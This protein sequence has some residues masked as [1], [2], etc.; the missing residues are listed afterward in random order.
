MKVS[1]TTP[2]PVLFPTLASAGYERCEH[3]REWQ[4]LCQDCGA[5]RSSDGWTGGSLDSPR[6]LWVLNRG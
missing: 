5:V 6:Q 3:P 2:V 4:T 1:P